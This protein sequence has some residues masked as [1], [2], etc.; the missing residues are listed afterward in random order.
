MERN[1]CTRQSRIFAG[2]PSALL[3][4]DKQLKLYGFQ[5]QA[6]QD[7]MFLDTEQVPAGY[8]WHV[9]DYCVAGKMN[10]DSGHSPQSVSANIW[11]MPPQAMGQAL[12]PDN[13][14]LNGISLAGVGILI[15]N[16]LNFIGYN[17]S[18]DD[19][20]VSLTYNPFSATRKTFQ[21]PSGWFVR[22]GIVNDNV[23][24]GAQIPAGTQLNL[25]LGISVVY[26]DFALAS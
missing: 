2:D 7:G 15:A 25:M 13:S 23:S 12:Q 19:G 5:A 3:C 26:R 6:D 16:S 4:V 10:L 22:F 8:F 1:F 24:P 11:L 9:S 21:V 17:G 20:F 14:N 18:P